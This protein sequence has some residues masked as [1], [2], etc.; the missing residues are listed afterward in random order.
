[1]VGVSSGLDLPRRCCLAVFGW[2]DGLNKN[3]L[4]FRDIWVRAGKQFVLHRS[5]PNEHVDASDDSTVTFHSTFN[6]HC[7]LRVINRIKD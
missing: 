3:S 6:Q 4:H 2:I 5:L 1:M 7:F